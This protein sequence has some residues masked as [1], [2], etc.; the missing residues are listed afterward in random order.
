MTNHSIYSPS[1]LSR[2]IACPGSVRLCEGIESKSSPWAEEGTVLHEVTAEMINAHFV[3]MQLGVS[4]DNEAFKALTSEQKEVVLF[5]FDFV[6][7]K[8]ESLQDDAGHP[9]IMVEHKVVC[10]N[11]EVYGTADCVL[12]GKDE[13]HVIDFKFGAGVPV[14]IV[15]NTQLTAYLDGVLNKFPKLHDVKKYIWIIQPRLGG[16]L[17]TEV[18]NEELE[19]FR[20]EVN[21]AVRL[22]KL[23]DAPVNPG[24]EQCRWCL[25]AGRCA[26]RVNKASEAS[27]EAF[28][29]MLTKGICSNEELAEVL[30]TKKETLATF[31]AIEALLFSELEEGKEVPG[32]IIGE[33]RG[34]R[35]WKE[36]ITFETLVSAFP[37]IEKEEVL[38]IEMVSPAGF[39][40]LIPAKER[41]KLDLWIDK[42]KGKNVIKMVDKKQEEC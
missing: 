8:V 22:S 39:E 14:S 40:K 13:V 18:T 31:E 10:H 20:A 28:K 7:Q 29:K 33:G 1:Q 35:K 16:E 19:A 32:Y 9:L 23:D 27:R 26:K 11:E 15:G 24:T 25:I 21:E 4:I 6:K 34:T 41:F 36:G 2:I 42:I 3:E 37:Q 12:I 5:C 17:G 30:K 38:K